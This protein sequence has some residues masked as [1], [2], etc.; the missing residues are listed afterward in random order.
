[1]RLIVLGSGTSFG[2]PVIGCECRVCKSTDPRNKRTR[3]AA[4]VEGDD[5]AVILIDTPPEIR[6]QL[7]NANVRKVDAVLY[8]HDHADHIHGIDDLRA[9]S[10]RCGELPV[11]GP[12]ETL[13][14]LEQRFGYIFDPRIVPAAGTT[15]PHLTR[16]PLEAG[17]EVVICGQTIL[18][19]EVDHGG[20]RVYGYR[21]GRLAYLTDVKTVP[22]HTKRMLE[23]VDFLVVN[24]LFER[25]HPTHL[26]IPEA[27][28][29]AADVGAKHTYLTHLTH[30]FAH[31]DLA[32]RL[33]TGVEPAYDGLSVVF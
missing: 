9:I 33:P 21:F 29:L 17:K 22:P 11:Y 10:V 19:L 26:S 15:K 23:G 18:P 6:L 13:D 2:V 4:L 32:S 20:T 5:G 12:P 14:G 1:V 7:V 24:A 3:V 31:A 16:T 25:E 8:T 28:A 30:D 27:V